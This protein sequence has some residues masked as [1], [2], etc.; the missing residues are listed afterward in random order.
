MGGFCWGGKGGGG[1]GGAEEQGEAGQ[2]SL[3]VCVLGAGAWYLEV[4]FGHNGL[5][6]SVRGG[7]QGRDHHL[8]F[9][10]RASTSFP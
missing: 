7:A 3:C 5:V 10:H 8:H 4:A 1:G 2:A 6:L 9:P